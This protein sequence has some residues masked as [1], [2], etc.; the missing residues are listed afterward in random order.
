MICLISNV[1]V[2]MDAMPAG[3][4][5]CSEEKP[6]ADTIQ[7]DSLLKAKA[8][9]DSLMRANTDSVVKAY[10]K[11]ME[12]DFSTKL[13]IGISSYSLDTAAHTLTIHLKEGTASQ[14]FTPKKV[15]NFYNGLK[16]ALPSP[17]GDYQ[18]HILA[19]NHDISELIPNAYR[20]SEA[21]DTA[22]LW[23]WPNGG[24]SN[25]TSNEWVRNM[26]RPT[27]IT[28]GLQGAHLTVW[29]S[30]GRYYDHQ[31]KSWR[32]QRPRLYSTTEDLF[33][34][35]IVVPFLLPMLEK[36]GAVTY[37]PRERDDQSIE[38]IVDNDQTLAEHVRIG[39]PADSIHSSG[40]LANASS[41]SL[42]SDS[43]VFVDSVVIRDLRNDGLLQG[44]YLE[45]VGTE[46]FRTCQTSG[47]AHIRDVYT[48][49]NPFQEG[50]ARCVRTVR[51]E[52]DASTFVWL[53][54]VNT[55]GMYAVYVSYARDAQAITDALYTV[56]HGGVDTRVRVNQRMGSGT[57]VYLGTFFFSA[58]GTQDNRITLTN[59][60]REDGIVTGDAVRLGGGMG[61]IARGN[62]TGNR[63][64]DGNATVSG[65]PRYLEGS[66]YW[67]QWAGMPPYIYDTKDGRNDYADDINARSNTMNYLAGNSVYESGA[68]G[69]GVP[70]ELSLA[71]HSDAGYTLDDDA[72]IGTLVISTLRGDGGDERFISGK[73]RLWNYDLAS[74]MQD[75]IMR[76]LTAPQ[77]TLPNAKTFSWNRREIYNRNYSESRKPEVSSAIIETL[78]HQ[79]FRDMLLGHDPNF[80][81]LLARSIYKGIVKFIAD[82]HSRDYVIQP[83]PVRGF[84]AIA[85]GDSV[86][87]NWEAQADSLEPTA[88]PTGYIVYT[89]LDG[90]DFDNGQLIVGR[91]TATLPIQ[92][93]KLYRFRVSA[94]NQG[95]ESFPSETLAALSASDE[96]TRILIVNGF[97]RL[98]SPAVVQSADSL[99][100]DIHKD[101]GVPYIQTSEYCGAQTGFLRK[102]AGKETAG[103][104]GYSGSELEGRIIAGNS[105]DYPSIHARAIIGNTNIKSSNNYG[106]A[107]IDDNS[108][109]F[110]NS[111]NSKFP[112]DANSSNTNIT[113]NHRTISSCSRDAFTQKTEEIAANQ[114][115]IDL[116]LGLQKDCGEQSILRYKTFDAPL[117]TALS[118][119][120]SIGGRI[121]V[122]GA[123]IGSDMQTDDERHFTAEVLGYEADFSLSSSGKYVS[124]SDKTLPLS[125]KTASTSDNKP[126]TSDK[127]PSSASKTFP[128]SNK[129]L[130][131]SAD[132]LS[133]GDTL[134]QNYIELFN[135][136]LRMGN[137]DFFIE[138]DLGKA[139]YAC[140]QTDVLRAQ[141][142]AKPLIFYSNGH[143]AAIHRKDVVA[144]G[145]P[146]ESIRQPQQR[147]AVIQTAIKL[148]EK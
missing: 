110:E 3:P 129:S 143:V 91:T 83:L 64:A 122:S 8:R 136:N 55:A 22:R 107:Q 76:D 21:K 56:R 43:I 95:G 108:D 142:H 104:L 81:F 144:I 120:R 69:L 39:V 38:L 50:T 132:T 24:I 2:G 119:F 100:L 126:S 92:R 111:R 37:C 57:W 12:M 125:D 94:V 67:A 131:T 98:S 32:W 6:L 72:T 102:R 138:N 41:D 52:E 133:L 114:D 40:N 101:I 85:D 44:N 79:N 47:F 14:V 118:V 135:N 96:K 73:S 15:D 147:S 34:R 13:A 140:Q 97:T 26:S 116:I 112:N 20:S 49:E 90:Q 148:L 89:A 77:S 54:N 127:T 30:H 61:N 145:F 59:V 63:G 109:N 16:E 88:T 60:S 46:A 45:Q 99:G 128:S 17:V 62:R 25:H 78:S 7:T 105:F 18:T 93:D 68:D 113:T 23:A 84:A 86:R 115:I 82:A 134:S 87:L 70:M 103:G 10:F 35:S 58:T 4:Q 123:Y 137:Q 124:T 71:I 11:N 28:K 29:P 33:T 75:Q 48:D 130:S 31:K 51:R 42:N 106:N 53:P 65:M 74:L 139:T 80:K 141:N 66:R 36:A 27:Q 1:F 121:L 117:R 19:F 146:I 5:I 9:A